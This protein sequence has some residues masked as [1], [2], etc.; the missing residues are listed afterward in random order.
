MVH[1]N[2]MTT[3]M[4]TTNKQGRFIANVQ[5]QRAAAEMVAALCLSSALPMQQPCIQSQVHKDKSGSHR[6]SPMTA[7][8]AL[9]ETVICNL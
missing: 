1:S 4:M 9:L 5:F 2:G 8:F 7:R 3:L 6:K